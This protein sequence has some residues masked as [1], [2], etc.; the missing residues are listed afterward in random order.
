MDEVAQFLISGAWERVRRQLQ[1]AE[2]NLLTGN[3]MMTKEWNLG[4][5]QHSIE[6]R[7]YFTGFPSGYETLMPMRIFWNMLIG[8]SIDT[9]KVLI[10]MSGSHPK[11]FPKPLNFFSRWR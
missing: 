3:G 9:E 8:P 11:P 1:S 7:V 4:R 5:V 10:Q 2:T 6:T